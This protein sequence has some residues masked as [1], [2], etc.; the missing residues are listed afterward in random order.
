MGVGIGL[1]RIGDQRLAN[2]GARHR[3]P[4]H[5]GVAFHG[6]GGI[7]VGRRA[8]RGGDRIERHPLAMRAPSIS[9]K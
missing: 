3:L 8:D 1:D 9:W 6:R 2:A 5:A 7:D 4:H